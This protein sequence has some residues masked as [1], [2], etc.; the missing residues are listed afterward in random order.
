MHRFH[1]FFLLIIFFSPFSLIT[2]S[3]SAVEIKH[4]AGILNLNTPPKKIVVLA[5]SFVDALAALGISPV[6]IADDGNKSRVMDSVREK[7]QD[8]QSVG[9]RYQPSLE[10]IAALQPDLIIADSARHL[11]IYHDLSIIAPTMMLK[12]RGV[13]YQE[14][15]EVLQQIA[16][17]VDKKQQLEKRLAEHQQLMNTIKQQIKSTST[18]QFAII[19]DKGMWLHSPTSFAGSVIKELSLSSPLQ[20]E[21]SEAY[22]QVSFEQLLSINPDWLF[23][24]QHTDNTVLD[25]WRKNP[26]WNM[27]SAHKSNQIINVPANVWSLAN[28]LIA[29]EQI[30]KTL[31]E[32]IQ[33]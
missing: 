7:I 27:L 6:G 26:L 1:C 22:L 33:K 13:T 19:S 3:A 28:G 4:G 11:S 15:L 12:S 17:A 23:V 9:S 31:A 2:S 21:T 5:F 25:K 24:G 14:N 10:A 20:K 32:Q 29:A 16:L 30:A 18:V 8:W